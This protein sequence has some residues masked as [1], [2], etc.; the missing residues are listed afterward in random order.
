MALLAPKRR[1]EVERPSFTR[2][3]DA[4]LGFI[5]GSG[6]LSGEFAQD[7][8][9]GLG[10]IAEMLDMGADIRGSIATGLASVVE[11]T[12]VPKREL[13]DRLLDL[14]SAAAHAETTNRV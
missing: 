2:S 4:A 3:V 14:R 9:L 5:E 7:L 8:L 10:L 12:Y 6:R 13:F 11:R 1:T